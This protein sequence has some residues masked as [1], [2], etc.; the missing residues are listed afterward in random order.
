MLTVLVDGGPT[1]CGLAGC[2]V[3][4][5]QPVGGGRHRL[6][7]S[8]AHRAEAR[9]RRLAGTPEP[10]PADALGSVLDRLGGVLDDLRRQE[11]SLRSIDMAR[12]A[13]DVARLRADATAEVLAAQQAA[14]AAAEEAARARG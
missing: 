14:A 5:S 2:D 7:C 4:V 10:A 9:R 1:V 11:A 13:V 12:R 8:N 3:P 6:H